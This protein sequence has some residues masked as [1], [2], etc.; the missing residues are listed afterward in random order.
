MFNQQSD[1]YDDIF[2]FYFPKYIYTNIYIY[3]RNISQSTVNSNNEHNPHSFH[4][5]F[6]YDL[7]TPLYNWP[8]PKQS[9]DK[10][11]Q[12]QKNKKKTEG[13]G[14]WKRKRERGKEKERKGKENW[15]FSKNRITGRGY[16]CWLNIYIIRDNTH[17]L[18]MYMYVRYVYLHL[19]DPF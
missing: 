9:W 1:S 16:Y 11:N 13:A 10:Q 2:I 12:I 18:S 3:I 4:M 7:I 6:I 5:S 19:Y 15:S 17:S 8:T 14:G